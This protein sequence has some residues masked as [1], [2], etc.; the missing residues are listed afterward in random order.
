MTTKNEQ[1]E[2]S[3]YFCEICH[4]DCYKKY[5][6]DRHI[7]TAKHIKTTK[8]MKNEALEQNEKY[9][10]SNCNKIYKDRA[11]LWRHKKKCDE[12]Q[13]YDSSYNEIKMLTNLVLEVVKQNKELINQNNEFQK[14]TNEV[15]KQNQELQKNVIEVLKNGT[16]NTN[17][18]NS[19]NKTFNLQV[20]LNETCK[21][22]MN[23]MDFVDSIKIQLSDIESIGE[24]G[25]VNGM[26]KLIIKHLNALDENMRPVHCSDPKRDSLYVKDANVWEKEDPDNK[27]IKKAIKRISHKNICALPE[28][29][30]KYPDCIYSDSNK[31]DQ[32]NKI[33]IEAMGGSGDNDAEKAEKIVKKIA[34]EVT[35]SKN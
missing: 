30:A 20:F 16:N 28:W 12:N 5:N 7:L 18:S 29:R 22:A 11:G 33:V 32:Y 19:H 3:Q 10:C 9:K 1:N 26:S 8:T 31:S 14:Q 13:I 35:I 17:I 34:K 2:Q 15:Q 4:Y 27:K 24:L 25:Y 23:I 6:Y 21:D